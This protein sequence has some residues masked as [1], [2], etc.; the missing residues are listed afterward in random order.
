MFYSGDFSYNGLRSDEYDVYLVSQTNR[1]LNEY[2]INHNDK[3]EI[4]LTFSNM[5]SND[6]PREWIDET[7]FF[8]HEWFISDEFKPFIS[9]D[10][11]EYAYMLRGVSLTK[12]FNNKMLGL[13]DVKFEVLDNYTYKRQV[14]SFNGSNRDHTV[15]NYSNCFD[16][17]SPL[18][19]L[20]DVNGGTIRITNRT[21]N[22]TLTISEVDKG[23]DV[24]IDN[25][26]GVI[27]DSNG[28]QLISKSNRDWIKLNKGTNIITLEGASF[29]NVTSMY[30]IMR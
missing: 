30:P 12:R 19:E 14:V 17:Y 15:Y 6:T 3:K 20:K 28:K 10:N 22:T 8:V 4:T 27:T 29:G 9:D 24:I 11:I 13:I 23:V 7:L 21:T 2:G 26:T 1:V 18:I 25:K 5:D 16:T